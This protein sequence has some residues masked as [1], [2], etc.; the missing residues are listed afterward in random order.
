MRS[1]A[2]R[3]SEGDGDSLIEKEE[4]VMS[5]IIGETLE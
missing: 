4:S 2:E 5:E 1:A 3:V